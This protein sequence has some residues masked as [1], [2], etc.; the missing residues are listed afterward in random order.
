V[1][2]AIFY[3]VVIFFV[4]VWLVFSL[5]LMLT[6]MRLMRKIE[7]VTDTVGEKLDSGISS[8]LPLLP[9]AILVGTEVMKHLR[10]RE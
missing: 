4:M 9:V 7:R 10:K 1:L 3:I 6:I 2:Q 8:W 5:V